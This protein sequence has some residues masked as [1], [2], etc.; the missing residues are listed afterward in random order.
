M[1]VSKSPDSTGIPTART[2]ATS[3]AVVP[4]SRT[5]GRKL[6]GALLA[7]VAVAALYP[8]S[9]EGL[10]TLA[11][12]EPAAAPQSPGSRFTPQQAP[13]SGA[14][15]VRIATGPSAGA[16]TGSLKTTRIERDGRSLEVV[17]GVALVRPRD[18]ARARDRL[19]ALG[20]RVLYVSSSGFWRVSVP[21][22]VGLET[23]LH[24]LEG[25]GS[26]PPSSRRESSGPPPWRMARSP[27]PICSGTWTRCAGATPTPAARSP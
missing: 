22:G 7:G 14:D 26:S 13:G 17:A 20:A 16:R 15:E 6:K 3:P 18:A 11:G 1:S 5:P 27:T 19:E 25:G 23:F 9:Q 12:R 8:V 21:A 4:V 24:R 2:V 10:R